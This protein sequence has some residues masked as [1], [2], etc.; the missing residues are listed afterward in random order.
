MR[1]YERLLD[2]VKIYTT[3][4]DEQEAVP[5]TRRQFDLG[6]KLAEELKKPECRTSVLMISVMYTVD[7]CNKRSG[8]KACNRLYRAYGYCS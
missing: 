2:Y 7:S 8:R 1:A 4:E 3:S 6:N 5:S